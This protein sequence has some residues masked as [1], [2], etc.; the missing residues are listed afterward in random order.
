[1]SLLSIVI[2]N[3]KQLGAA[4]QRRRKEQELT[5]SELGVRMNTRQATVSKLEKGEPATQLQTVMNALT[6][7]GLE[8]VV[9]PRTTSSVKELE[10]LF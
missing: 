10:D 6:A 8:L 2:R 4:I 1:L 9:R 5:Q 3:T 7:L